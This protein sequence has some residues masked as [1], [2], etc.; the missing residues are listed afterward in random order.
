MSNIVTNVCRRLR[1]SPTQKAVLMCLA[2]FC[3]DDGKDWHSIASMME[4]TC[5]G[6][7]TVIDALKALED[8]GLIVIERSFGNNNK[9][10]LQIRRI[11]ERP[12]NQCTS[13]TGAGGAP[14]QEAHDTSAPAAPPP[15][16]VAHKPVRVAHP[17]HVEP[18]GKHQE[19][20]KR[21]KQQRKAKSALRSL[22]DDFSVSP[23][24]EAWAIK[25]GHTNLQ[26]HLEV[27]TLKCRA[28]GLVSDDWDAKFQLAILE[29]WAKVGAV[30]AEPQWRREQRER[31]EA[32]LGPYAAKRSKHTGFDSQDYGEGVSDGRIV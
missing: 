16:H 3:H 2:D 4:W 12:E 7:R 8:A 15:V 30:D 21:E 17:N 13:R 18:S 26:A 28:G 20:P 11:A 9:T 23:Q 32:A 24:V 22:P 31:N 5:L 25:S 10:F 6:K 27:F 19:P 14:V 1:M 29:N